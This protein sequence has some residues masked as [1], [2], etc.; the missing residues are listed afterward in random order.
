MTISSVCVYCGASD[1]VADHYKVLARQVGVALTEN[2][3]QLVYGG[4]E[5]GL[6]GIVADSA[7]ETGGYV[8][9]IIPHN[10]RSD[11]NP[12][13]GLSELHIV[14]NMHN[15]K[16]LMVDKSDAFLILPG[17]FGTLDEA[18]EILTW[19]K[20]QF[21]NKPIILLNHKG[22]WDPFI[23]LVNRLINEGFAAPHDTALFHVA[24]NVEEVLS[25]LKHDHTLSIA[26]KTDKM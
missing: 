8:V 3:Y 19:R 17:G 11:E 10:I 2:K 4:A 20:L 6:M 5:I 13:S 9:G 26:P 15:R 7:M 23:E 16:Q 1:S 12:H 18:F 25:F 21:H 22:F 24:D 14:S